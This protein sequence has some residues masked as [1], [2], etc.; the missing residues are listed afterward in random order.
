MD[1]GTFGSMSIRIYGAALRSAAAEAK[2]IL[3]EMASE[4]LKTPKAQLRVEN[5][6]VFAISDKKMQV[7]FAQLAK[8]QKI[9][10]KLDQKSR[11][12]ISFGI[13][14]IGTSPMRFDVRAKVTGKAQYAGDIRFPGLMY[15]KVLRPPAHGAKPKN[16]DTSA[17]EKSRELSLL[18]KKD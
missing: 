13:T 4:Q 6:V 9:T 15:A 3:L 7:T 17:A 5:G 1:M 2:A 10:R 18:K 16:A 12:E 11:I 8:G 14:I